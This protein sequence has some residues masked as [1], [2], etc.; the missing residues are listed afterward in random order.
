MWKPVVIL[1]N[2]GLAMSAQN[3]GGPAPSNGGVGAVKA[4]GNG[5]APGAGAEAGLQSMLFE[6]LER[7]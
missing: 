7:K 3:Y 6:F 5:A 2:L 4:E 1:L